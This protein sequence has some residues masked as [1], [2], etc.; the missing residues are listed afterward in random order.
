MD[1]IRLL[2]DQMVVEFS[3]ESVFAYL[4]YRNIIAA[5]LM[6]RLFARAFHELSPEGPPD[7]EQ[8]SVLTA[9]PGIGIREAVELVTRLP[10]RHPDRFVIDPTAGPDVAPTAPIG[11]FYFE[12]GL[13]AARSAY[14]VSPTL[15][16]DTFRDMVR[17]YEGRDLDQTEDET[18]R[19]YKLGK[20]QEI[21][22]W[23]DDDLFIAVG[24]GSQRI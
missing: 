1:S 5:A 13:G 2:D 10:T 23:A 16:D 3:W 4:G 18:Y 14:M 20:V 24:V 9:F 6:T 8:L 12:I 11:R 15:L 7:R 19:N 17:R 21:R 22:D